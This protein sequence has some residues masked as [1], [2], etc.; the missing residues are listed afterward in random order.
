[1]STFDAANNLT[2]K[3]PANHHQIMI[4][5][6]GSNALPPDPMPDMIVGDTVEYLSNVPGEVRIQFTG[7]SPFRKDQTQMTSVPGGQTLTLLTGSSNPFDCR[8]FITPLNGKELG[9]SPS[10]PLS[11]GH[12]KVTPP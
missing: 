1:M 2:S 11:G 12:H 7:A 5:L 8:C 10:T 4:T 3:R 6:E 9:W